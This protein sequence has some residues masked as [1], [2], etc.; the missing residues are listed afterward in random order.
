M[1]LVLKSSN[2][3]VSI[4]PQFGGLLNAMIVTTKINK[5]NIIDGYSSEADVINNIHKD[6]KG[7]KLSPFPN[8]VKDGVYTFKNESFELDQNFKQENNAIH[9][10]LYDQPFSVISQSQNEIHLEYH[11]QGNREG[12]PFQFVINIKYILNDSSLI[13][14]TIIKN[15]GTKTLP[16]GDGFH[17]YFKLDQQ[18]D[19]VS[20][21][22]PQVL[23]LEVDNRMIPTTKELPFHDFQNEELINDSVFDTCF[24]LKNN[25]DR[26]TTT[27]KSSIIQI[28]IWQETGFNKYNFLQVYT[29]PSRQSIAIEPM[30]C[31]PDAF[32]NQMGLIE[33]APDQ[34][35]ELSYGVD[36]S[37]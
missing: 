21:T 34:S 23:E 26:A 6:F 1:E 19:Q 12:Y 25:S 8:R 30:T 5:I 13:C 7:T 28:S 35:I 2:C 27:L 29:P 24:A 16:I 4:L 37:F 32:N 9:G 33:L 10:L 3:Q 22:L 11:Y 14:N 18:I 36:V 15:C 20:M 17:P 31:A